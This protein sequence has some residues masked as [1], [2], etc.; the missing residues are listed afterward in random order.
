VIRVLLLLLFVAC[1]TE[2]P[3]KLQL[4]DAPPGGD[5]EPIVAGELA[6]AAVAGDALLVYVG[7]TWCEPCRAFHD[8]AAAGALDDKLGALRLLVFDA[9][10]DSDALE[11]AGYHSNLIPLFAV[12]R[13][14]GR[15]SGKQTEGAFKD[16]DAVTQLVP[17]IKALIGR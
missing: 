8:A 14:D 15:A 13:S 11:G 3:R 17:R 12:P 5:V 9:D 4:I 1:S 6:Q 2:T 16:R 7:A 10:R